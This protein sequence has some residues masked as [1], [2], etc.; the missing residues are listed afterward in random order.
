[1]T[2]APLLDWMNRCLQNMGKPSDPEW[3]H[4]KHLGCTLW[5]EIVFLKRS[6]T[7]IW[8]RGVFILQ[9]C[10]RYAEMQPKMKNL[11]LQ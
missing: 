8:S 3:S 1:M 11:N 7:A 9:H 6:K 2:I 10:F 5:K 4:I